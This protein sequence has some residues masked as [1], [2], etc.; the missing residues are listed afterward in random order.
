M[1]GIL[2]DAFDQ[3]STSHIPR[4]G[5]IETNTSV[6]SGQE[7]SVFRGTIVPLA[8]RCASQAL[9]V[10]HTALNN[11]I[12]AGPTYAFTPGSTT[13][14]VG[15]AAKAPLFTQP[16]DLVR[17]YDQSGSLEYPACQLRVMIEQT[18]LIQIIRG[19]D[20]FSHSASFVG[21]GNAVRALRPRDSADI[22]AT[23][24]TPIVNDT[25][26]FFEFVF[27]IHG[28]TG[29]V[30]LFINGASAASATGIDT[31]ESGLTN[32]GAVSLGRVQQYTDTATNAANYL[33]F[34]D[35]Y[36]LDDTGTELNARLGDVRV[37]YI[38]NQTD[39]VA[40]GTNQG[41]TPSTGTDHGAL[42]DESTP[43]DDSTYISATT[44]GLRDSFNYPA[45][46]ISAGTIHA[47]IVAPCARKDDSGLKE[48]STVVRSGGSNYDGTAQSVSTET[49]K[50]YPQIYAVNP[51][52]GVAFTVAGVNAAEFGCKVTT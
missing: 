15:F 50:Y 14:V 21:G 24:A 25:Y 32:W 48:L 52:T 4:W 46:S 22:L 27:T 13:G 38:A 34:D 8:G 17:I 45:I 18:G 6:L 35:F 43:D 30:E 42:V 41:W 33:D 39:A 3:Y 10:K 47:V 44:A 2:F 51:A 20:A 19:A 26:Y 29:A 1:A 49:Y 37:E 9:R 40:I 23:T 7:Y 5:W 28:S 16:M 36:V 11:A 31:D 12:A